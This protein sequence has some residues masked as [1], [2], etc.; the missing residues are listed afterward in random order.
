M[1]FKIIKAETR[2]A[3]MITWF[4]G[5]QNKI[6][7]FVVGG[8]ARSKLETVAVEMEAQDYAFY[9]TTAKA[10]PIAIYQAFGFNLLPSVKASGSVTFSSGTPAA[11]DILIPA[12]TQVAT[13]GSSTTAEKVYETTAAAT[14]AAGQSSVSVTVAA[15]I[16]GMSGNTA[17]NTITSL[18]TTIS[19][20][21]SITNP[22]SISNGKDQEDEAERQARFQAFIASLTRGTAAA[23][24][25]AAKMA[26]TG[27]ETVRDAAVS[28]PPATGSAGTCT[29]YLYNGAK[30]S[31]AASAPLIAAAQAIIDGNATTGTPGYKAAG[32]VVTVSAA[33]VQAVTV[34][35][36]V[37]KLSS[38]VSA[39]VQ[40]AVT[41]AINTYFDSMRIGTAFLLYELIERIM[42]TTGVYNAA[43][44]APAGDQAA[45][46]G[47]VYIPGTITVTVT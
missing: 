21:S 33:T 19:G 25:Y 18:K 27:T 22:A 29:V 9:V 36:S 37:N 43:V 23:L 8:K 41:A 30:A 26:T 44:S 17:A 46:T 13:I 15:L 38:A 40:A 34:T 16:A 20:I 24:I 7:D 3:N 35:V 5:I 14:I 6:T 11:S 4:A 10:I 12:G 1:S 42:G 28:G 39:T 45:T 47:R 31:P 32:V 2:L